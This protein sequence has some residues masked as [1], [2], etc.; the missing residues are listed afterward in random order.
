MT[1]LRIASRV[2]VGVLVVGLLGLAGL[3][4]TAF[5]S[6]FRALQT[7]TQE[8]I[9]WSATQVEFELARFLA[10][11]GMFGAGVEEVD[12]DQVRL[13]YDVLWSRLALFDD[14]A[15][16]RRLKAYDAEEGRV[17]SLYDAVR[18]HEAEIVGLHDGDRAAA[19]ALIAVFAPH[20]DALRRFTLSVLHGEEAQRA[21][22]RDSMRASAEQTLYLTLGALA[23]ALA[24]LAALMV[25]NRR[26]TALAETNRRLAEQAEAASR[27]KSRFL[28][29]MSHE[30]RTPMN[31]VLGLLALARQPGLPRPQLR[32]I[33]QAEQSGRAMVEILSDLLDLSAMEEEAFEFDRRPFSVHALASELT[34]LCAPLAR[35]KGV[36]IAVQVAPGMPAAV[37]GDPRRLRQAIMRLASYVLETAGTHDV[38]LEFD[39]RDGMLRA[40]LSFGYGQDGVVWNPALILGTPENCGQFAADALGPAVARMMLQRMGGGLSVELAEGGKVHVLAS[41]PAAAIATGAPKVVIV[42]QS[43]ALGAICAAA[44]HGVETRIGADGVDADVSAVL[45]EAGGEDEA[46]RVAELRRRFPH[47]ALIALGTPSDPAAFDGVAPLPIDAG[48]LRAMVAPDTD[49]PAPAQGAAPAS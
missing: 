40:R 26:L 27:A 5:R 24:G 2:I 4:V 33:E 6:D 23:V 32:L 35:R 45:L 29:M 21:A 37:M 12:A 43:R 7:A 18:A 8:N 17:A 38:A 48:A 1:G 39:C 19:R 16:G 47:A 34:E 14:S 30:L 22:I 15:S 41:V 11:L 10:A 9:I 44:L 3:G 25:Q 46:A 20:Q 42:T 31:G 49:R 36:A 28:A 13:R